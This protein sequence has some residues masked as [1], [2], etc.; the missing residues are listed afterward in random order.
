MSIKNILY[1]LVTALIIMSCETDFYPKPK[2]FN[3]IEIAPA[4]YLSLADSLPYQFEYSSQA[5]VS[6]DSSWISERYWLDLSYQ[7]LGAT[8]QITYK[9]IGGSQKILNELLSDS[10]KLTSKHNVKAYAIDEAVVSLNNGDMATIMELSGQVPS[11]FQFHTTD[12]VNH[13][14]RG[15][16]YF[17]SSTKNDSLAPVINYIKQDMMHLLNTLR[18]DE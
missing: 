18:W 9:P 2:G 6:Q 14:L 15:A 11:Q 17:K 13:F 10:Y 7:R 8:V 16:L 3:R 4:Q 1:I 12:S 5:V